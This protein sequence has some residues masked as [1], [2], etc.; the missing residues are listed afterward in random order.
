MSKV[1]DMLRSLSYLGGFQWLDERL[2]LPAIGVPKLIHGVEM[3]AILI[4]SYEIEGI[5]VVPLP[6]CNFTIVTRSTAVQ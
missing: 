4:V 3:K 5:L 2:N 6:R 1:P